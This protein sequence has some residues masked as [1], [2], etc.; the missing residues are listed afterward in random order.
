MLFIICETTGI[1]SANA[2]S[3]E[4]DV[5][6]RAEWLSDLVDTFEMTVEDD[7]Y[8][9]NYFSDLESSS[10][11]YQ[12]ILV[13]VQFGVVNVEA[14]DPIYPNDP[15]TREFAASTLN[16][17]LG[18]QMEKQDTT[19][20][21]SDSA[22]VTD[23]DSAQI[24]VNHGWFTL[25]GGKFC[26]Q[27]KVTSDE[28]TH[29]LAD[30]K[31]IW[32]STDVDRNYD[33]KYTLANGVIEIPE[34][35]DTYLLDDGRVY[36]A[37]CPKEISVG[38][39]FAVHLN[40]IPCVYKAE[41]IEK[42]N[43]DY[44]ITVSELSHDEAYKE[45]DM[46]GTVDASA[47]QIGEA[48][49][50]LK[51]DY[52][53]E[54]GNTVSRRKARG[55]VNLDKYTSLKV[56]GKI[57]VVD[58][59]VSLDVKMKNV[60]IDYAISLTGETFVKLRGDSDVTCKCDFDAGKSMGLGEVP[61]LPAQIPGVGGIDLIMEVSFGGKFNYKTS[62][63][64]V[65]GL[66]YSKANGFR[67]IKNFN[68][69]SFT[70]TCEANVSA[71]L[72]V[73][74]GVTGSALP[75]KGYVYTTVG[76]K[77]VFRYAS[78]NDGLPKGCTTVVAYVYA[79]TGAEASIKLLGVDASISKETEL[80]GEDNSPIRVYHHYEDGKEVIKCSRGNDFKYYTNINSRYWGNGWTEG[81]G[82]Y[83]YDE[84]GNKVP[85]YTYTLDE[86]NNA[87]ITGY[88]GR[89]AY[90]HIPE[91]VD[92]YT[93]VEIGVAAFQGKKCI[94][95][96]EI[97]NTVTVIEAGAFGNCTN[98]MQIKIPDN[99]T[100]IG[101]TAFI[102][103]KKLQDVSLPKNL[104]CIGA[105]AFY[106]CDGLEEINV[107]CNIK[108]IPNTFYW[109]D[110]RYG[111]IF[112]ECD[113]LKEINF[114][115]GITTV[116]SIFGSCKSLESVEIPDT[117]TTIEDG[118]FGDCVNLENIKIPDSV[119]KIGSIAF[120]SCKK[121]Q[122]VKLPKYLTSIGAWA[123]Y[124]CD[125]LEEIN[126]PCNIQEIPDTFYWGYWRYGCIFEEC[127]NLKKLNFDEGITTVPSI[128]GSC[129]S[130]ESVEI[131]D[132]VTTIED[133]AFGD[134]VNLENI[135]IP[136]SV[137]KIGSIAFISCK[138][139][140]NVKLPKYLTS[141][142]AWAF[143]DC[144]GLEEI[145]I[146]CNIQEIPNTFY[147]GDWR[148]GC[149]F[150]ECDNLKKLNFDEGITTVPSI[151]GSCK[152]LESVKIP[153]TVEKIAG[154]AFANCISL[155]QVIIPNTV[156]TIEDCAFLNCSSL[157]EIELPNEITSMGI[158]I[159]SGCT[160][161][162][163][164]TL[165][166]KIEYI[167][168]RMFENCTSLENITLPDTVITINDN[169]FNGC[170]S[171]K[172]IE[173]GKS[174]K[175]ISE[176]AFT[177]CTSLTNIKIPDTVEKIEK[178][179]FYN[180]SSLEKIEL[181]KSLTWIG[182][183]TFYNCDALTSIEI[184]DSVTGL[185]EQIFYDCDSLTDV[186]LSTGIKKIPDSAFEHCDKLA[187]IVLPYRVESIGNNVFK[188]DV[189][190]TEITIPRATTSIGSSVF[191][192]LDKMT[193]YGVPGTY[194]ETYAKE[195]G[196]KFVSKE[197]K[198]TK[199][200]L[201][202]N[203]LTLNNGTRYTLK[204]SV[205][206]EDFTD[207]VTWKSTNTDVATIDSDGVIN[208]RATGN[209]MIKVMVGEQNVTCNVKVVQPV[210]SISLNRENLSLDALETHQL[211]PN[212]YP[213]NAENQNIEW[214]SE[215]ETIATVSDAGLVKAVKEGTTTITATAKD[216]S[217][218]TA[219]CTV[220]VKN[221]AYVVKNVEELESPHNYKNNC[222]DF[223][224]Y[225]MENESFLNVTFDSRTEIED[226][227]DYIYIYNADGT[228]VGKYTGKEL[229]GATVKVTGDTVKIKLVSDGAGNAWG[230]K[231]SDITGTSAKLPQS[232]SVNEHINKR[233]ND[234]QFNLDAVRTVGDGVLSYRSED[235]EVASVDNSGNVTIKGV[236]TVYIIITAAETDEYKETRKTVELVVDKAQQNPEIICNTDT[237]IEGQQIQ[238]V[239]NNSIGDVVYE[240]E[241]TQIA[242]INDT[243]LITGIAAGD[244]G[245][246]IIV[247]GN[248]YYESWTKRIILHVVKKQENIV[249]LTECEIKLSDT[250]YVYD[251][252]EIRPEVTVSYNGTMLTEGAD[253]I[254]SYENN[255]DPGTATVTIEAVE[256]SGYIGTV[257]KNFAIRAVLD[258]YVTVV[259]PGAFKGCAN[260]TN[261][262]IRSTVTGIGEQAFADCKNLRNIY[263]YGNC[264]ETG[265]D[266]FQNVTANAYYPYNDLTWSM[267]K[268]Q[269][270]GGNITWCPWNPQTGEPA[271]RDL[272]ICEMTVSAKDLTYNGKAQTPQ[273][274]VTDSGKVLQ[275]G[276]DYTVTYENNVKAGTA[277]VTATGAGI[278]GGSITT[279][280]AI[281]KASN[282]I[283]VS[284]ITKTASSKSQTVKTTVRA[285]GGAKLTYSS[286]NKSV[287]V[288][289]T[290]K[291]T[292]AKN[293]AG[294]AV[295]TV[296]S[297]ETSCYK[298]ASKKFNVTVKPAAVTISKA[299]NSAK[300]K[301]T[302][303]W[304]KNTTCSGYAVQYSTDKS[305]KKG[306]KTVYISKNSTVKATLSKLTKGKTYYVRIASYKKSGS[307][308]IYSA[309]SKVKSVKVK[310]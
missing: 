167:A 105:W 120:I 217:G 54:K 200:T 44:I 305:F 32:N 11:Y 145:N 103:C 191:S 237:I 117:V 189:A 274:T 135:K 286:N 13:A 171:L 40:G 245:I 19:Y 272:S 240:S 50:G 139:L 192:Y 208:A 255:I 301:I 89:A 170:T 261:V 281:S 256:N 109:G 162:T 23:K 29:M 80:Y 150:E 137:T 133:G 62:G 35:T 159:F 61:L 147:W 243:G 36:I 75:I 77:A 175:Y 212:I 42:D 119:T 92:G 303:S 39:S 262:N 287:K 209:A 69:K 166:N 34:G 219:K 194:V 46:Q 156:K 267:D 213:G 164:I 202:K 24:A 10:E 163:D 282:T 296:K 222:S 176:Y 18:Y 198:A 304:K 246:N 302:V 131:P 152:S 126:I 177:N 244:V 70:V 108:E 196:I 71:G 285:Y 14:G 173:W 66:S 76:G 278:Y 252:G 142:G 22:D 214:K 87:T 95:K 174:L 25:I 232:I 132:T 268:L 102:S 55:S 48:A 185:G 168:A 224:M 16:F 178:G 239:T 113:N 263:F 115:E 165:S 225:T 283:K 107:P 85:L 269:D 229:S 195:N 1:V 223:W 17:C 88:K 45:A 210:I 124:D 127:D 5:V 257:Q 179:T 96:V 130:L 251:G 148:Y 265:K 310:K 180:N 56:S 4:T 112:A 292:I 27:N 110:W 38:D 186:K 97:P 111:C 98:L 59:S 154:S 231:V 143:Y 101:S 12:K 65:T 273:I 94:E 248:Q 20:T 99:V 226:G 41:K 235:T 280:F 181:S 52:S 161:L 73:R 284:D 2:K 67:I 236:G 295:I 207:E 233:F 307:T 90:L 187:S 169:A 160:S 8:P 197:V 47:L 275:E 211:V 157:K 72:K 188:N 205:E 93:V 260:L 37:E 86:E 136:D 100:K 51:V 141:I 33:S 238:I 58:Q 30:A 129:K 153:D 249:L 104:T 15:T 242:S 114:D 258:E 201:D 81:I 289:K 128:F 21:F 288:D 68:A 279:R 123:F 7:N 60:K 82:D 64:L 43:S 144:D 290:G 220:T 151:F 270:Y 122:N 298:A 203:E 204:L 276:V 221:T 31:T 146:P 277:T 28:V 140:Q 306:V 63:Y 254:L 106:D 234:A 264:P 291:L 155:K 228:E 271:R 308:K 53:E 227:F 253:Y 183:R 134:C 259:Q 184:P 9:D 182:Y 116:P 230:F 118:A 309:W 299:S 26:P 250:A 138:K 125:G 83:G 206:P 57:K 241:N 84:N 190:L 49:D 199:V 158:Y 78:Y 74:M 293:F 215:D 294:K 266:M 297:S 91:T 172:N 218:V 300:Q 6:T 149:I 193:I 247:E 79:S 121:L 216:G 3:K